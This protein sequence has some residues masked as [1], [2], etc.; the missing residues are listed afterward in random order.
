MKMMNRNHKIQHT[1]SITPNTMVSASAAT[2]NDETDVSSQ[3]TG[4]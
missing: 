4:Y 3:F 1:I 2:K